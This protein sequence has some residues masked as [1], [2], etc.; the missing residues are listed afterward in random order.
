MACSRPTAIDS[1]AL[2]TYVSRAWQKWFSTGAWWLLIIRGA[3]TQSQLDTTYPVSRLSIRQDTLSNHVLLLVIWGDDCQQQFPIKS[4]GIAHWN[5]FLFQINF[6]PWDAQVDEKLTRMGDCTA[7]G[8]VEQLLPYLRWSH[9][10]LLMPR[11]MGS[12]WLVGLMDLNFFGQLSRT[13]F[14]HTYQIPGMSLG[15]ARS[16]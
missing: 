15:N 12:Q 11:I 7:Q 13:H 10:D 1:R 14:I 9:H 16:R 2:M 8:L 5:W 3:S 4:D 6:Y